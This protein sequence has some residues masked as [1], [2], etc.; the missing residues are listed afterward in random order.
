[1]R[2]QSLVIT[3]IEGGWFFVSHGDRFNERM[4]FEEMLG[5]VAAVLMPEKRPCAAWLKTASEERRMT[6]ALAVSRI[7]LETSED[8]AR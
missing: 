7:N 8:V 2:G 4:S 1:M 3:P 5:V 6:E